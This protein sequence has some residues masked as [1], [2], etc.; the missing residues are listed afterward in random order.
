MTTSAQTD[1]RTAVSTS[2]YPECRL[3]QG[4]DDLDGAFRRLWETMNEITPEENARRMEV[5]ERVAAESIAYQK[6]Q[7]EARAG[8]RLNK[9]SAD[10]EFVTAFDNALAKAHGLQRMEAARTV[11][12][13]TAH[14]LCGH[15]EGTTIARL[16]NI[17][18]RY[19]SKTA[20]NAGARLARAMAADPHSVRDPL[21]ILEHRCKE[22]T[23]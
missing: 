17:Y 22:A 18:V 5:A 7:A 12:K 1:G 15:I 10:G 13:A 9:P 11:A 8:R 4:K 6:Q 21:S 23:T 3:L 20:R 2:T 16:A 19:G 14:F